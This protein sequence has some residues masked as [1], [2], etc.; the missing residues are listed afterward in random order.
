VPPFFPY[1]GRLEVAPVVEDEHYPVA[2]VSPQEAVD[3]MLEQR[4]LGRPDLHDAMGGGSRVSEFFSGKRELSKAQVEALHRLL[5]IPTDVLMGLG[6]GWVPLPG[7]LS[8]V[9][10]PPTDRR[11]RT[12]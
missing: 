10:A 3:F 4:N 5:G 2:P 6:S 11:A 7:R 1:R 9:W 12:P 8:I